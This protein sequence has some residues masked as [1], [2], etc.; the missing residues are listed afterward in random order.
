MVFIIFTKIII[1]KE[2]PK[3]KCCQD[4]SGYYLGTI[5]PK[6]NK[7]FR[8]VI[9]E[10]KQEKLEEV[11]EDFYYEQSK[12]YEDE[13][14]PMFDISR[15]LVAGFID[16]AKWQQERMYSEEEVNDLLEMLKRSIAE[17]IHLKY[18]YKD[19][20]HCMKYLFDCETIIE[21]F[22]KK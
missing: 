5:C 10:P 4:V 17:I 12:A 8:S 9:Q 19:I 2:E 16:G 14:E 13:C 7:P 22:K 20:G 6:C 21:Q 15:Y 18:T 3:Q 11:A 1:P